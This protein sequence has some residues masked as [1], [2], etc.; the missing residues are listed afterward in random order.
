MT[1]LQ[2]VS[3]FQKENTRAFSQILKMLQNL[4]TV[5]FDEFCEKD[6]RILPWLLFP[7][8]HPEFLN[9]NFGDFW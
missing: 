7:K 4:H 6:F 1:K 9:S 3:V 2:N 8:K 5:N